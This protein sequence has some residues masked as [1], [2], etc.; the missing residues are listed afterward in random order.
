MLAPL[1]ARLLAI[2]AFFDRFEQPH[3]GEP[4]PLRPCR[5]G[6]PVEEDSVWAPKTARRAGCSLVELASNPN[7]RAGCSLASLPLW[8]VQRPC[9]R[10]VMIVN[11]NL[12]FGQPPGLTPAPAPWCPVGRPCRETLSGD[13][14]GR[15][16]RETLSGDPVGKPCRETL[17]GDPV[18]RLCRE[19]LSG[20]PVGRPCRETTTFSS[21]PTTFA[22]VR[23][24]LRAFE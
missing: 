12:P 20:D 5:S 22:P 15:P 18:G 7:G 3:R 1:V 17:S 21:V 14:V 8:S 19:T 13:P 2:R 16:C 10:P 9:G 4:A 23:V 11:C 24:A 6:T